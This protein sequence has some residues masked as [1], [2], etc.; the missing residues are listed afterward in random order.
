MSSS[1]TVLRA[2]SSA[3]SKSWTEVVDT[4]VGACIR[5]HLK[6]VGGQYAAL[7]KSVVHCEGFGYRTI[8]SDARR[9]PVM[10]LTHNVR[11]QHR[12]A[13]FLHD[14][15][16]SVAIHRVKGFRQIHECSVEVTVQ[17]IEKDT[18]EDLPGDV[19]QR[20]ASAI[21]TELPV[22]LPFVEMADGHVF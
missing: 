14:F 9:H 13:E 18:G 16:Q 1:V 22:P 6:R 8:D 19:E 5:R 3:K 15:P 21:I 20:D 10:K 7:L 2:Q 4:C 11:L 12:T 17:T